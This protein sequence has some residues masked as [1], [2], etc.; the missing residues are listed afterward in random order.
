MAGVL[1]ELPLD[2]ESF[3][4]GYPIRRA[5]PDARLLRDTVLHNML[6]LEMKYL[7]NPDYF[8]LIQTDVEPWMRDTVAKWML[9]VGVCD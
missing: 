6:Q 3:A 9:E 7:P 1:Q 5:F 4:C 2:V 8:R